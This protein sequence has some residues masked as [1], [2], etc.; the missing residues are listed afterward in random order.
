MRI[1]TI[2]FTAAVVLA[3]PAVAAAQD[4]DVF[5]TPAPSAAPQGPGAGPGAGPGPG[6]HHR[7]GREAMRQRL[8]QEIEAHGGRLTRE[9]VMAS[10][11]ARFD[12]LDTDHD[13]RLTREEIV[14]GMQR[15]R[16]A[17]PQA[18]GERPLPAG[19]GGQRF[20]RIFGRLD[21]DRDGT[22]SLQEFMVPAERMFARLDPAGTGVITA[23]QVRAQR[24]PN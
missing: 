14:A 1:R 15:Q 17:N 2:L 21:T 6:R 9:D 19:R 12:A 24:R 7:H 18:A 5:D 13:G 4:L 11:Q 16:P 3:M 10:R 23:D 22:L 20:D 8:L